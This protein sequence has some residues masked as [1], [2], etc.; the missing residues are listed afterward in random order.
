MKK[1]V[2]ILQQFFKLK[3]NK[4]I[5]DKDVSSLA[6]DYTPY[7][8]RFVVKNTKKA[9]QIFILLQKSGIPVSTWPDLPPE[10]LADKTKHKVSIALRA[11]IFLL[12]VH[13]SVKLSKIE[14]SL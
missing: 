9:E 8:A 10:V 11:K 3:I 2:T 13:Q 6:G 12:P 7:L 5:I 1:C 4:K 14:S